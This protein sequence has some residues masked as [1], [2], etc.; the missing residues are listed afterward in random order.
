MMV[1]LN[2]Y[3]KKVRHYDPPFPVE[4]HYGAI[5]QEW[6]NQQKV[7]KL[8]WIAASL[9]SRFL[10]QHP[11]LISNSDEL[12]SIGCLKIVETVDRGYP[13]DTLGAVCFTNARRGMEDFINGL[14]S[15]IKVGT[16]TRYKNKK[17]GKTTINTQGPMPL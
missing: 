7:E 3:S 13:L 8:L 6:T 14:D 5:E 17:I 1:R 9:T 4:R 16:T 15:V 10:G 12:F 2:T 11:F